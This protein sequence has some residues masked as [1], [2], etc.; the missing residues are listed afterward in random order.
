VLEIAQRNQDD[1]IVHAPFSG[2]VTD[3]AAQQG[4]IVSPSS[5]GGGFTRTGICTIVDMDSLEAEVDVSENFIQRV[6]A[7]Q[8]A[9]VRLNAYPDWEIPASVIAIIPTA[10]RSKATVKVRVGFK[11]KDPRI[12]PEMGARVAFL[13]A[14][15]PATASSAADAPHGIVLPADAVLAQGDTG[16]VFVIEGNSVTRRSVRLGPRTSDGQ[17]ILSGISAGTR[18]AA[19]DLTHLTDNAK[20]SVHEG[21]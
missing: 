16:T 10:D 2:V 12:L 7:G 1:T 11:Q 13:A 6:R 21:S 15:A 5:A 4:E 20:V 9:T 14:P 17:V 3:K 19:G 18:V 8:P